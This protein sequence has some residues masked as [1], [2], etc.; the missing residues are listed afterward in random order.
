MEIKEECLAYLGQYYKE[1]FFGTANK[2]YRSMTG[3]DLKHRLNRLSQE[4]LNGVEKPNELN[5][6]HAMF[7]KVCAYLMHKEERLKPGPALDQLKEN[8]KKME[9]FCGMLAAK[10]MEYLPE[11]TEEELEHVLKMQG[12][13]R[14]L[15]TNSLERAYQLFYLPKTIKKGIRESVKRRPEDEY[16]ETRAM[17]RRFILHIGP[18]NSGKTHDALERLKTASHGAYFGPLRLLALEVYDRLNGEN[19]PCSMI[20]YSDNSSSLTFCSSNAE[21]GASSTA[22]GVLPNSIG[23]AAVGSN[24]ITNAAQSKTLN[25]NFRIKHSPF[26]SLFCVPL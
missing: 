5:D 20:T 23:K 26:Y 12:I 7:A 21:V 3:A 14:Y 24:P 1:L 2:R 15:L 11:L 25:N 4:T 13:R 18:T 10:D 22:S 17:K 8:W 9:D 6:I 16:P 19:I